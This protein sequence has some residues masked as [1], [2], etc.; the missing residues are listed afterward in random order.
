MSNWWRPMP[1]LTLP[2]APG[3]AEAYRKRTGRDLL[4]DIPLIS[5][6]G[7]D[8]AECRIAFWDI[9]GQMTADAFFGTISDWCRAHGFR[10]GGHLMGEEISTPRRSTA[11]RPSRPMCRGWPRCT[12][13]ARVN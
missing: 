7:A 10:S 13:A 4:D 8:S 11:S 2:S 5:A 3:L 12:P 1:Y 6:D 9:A